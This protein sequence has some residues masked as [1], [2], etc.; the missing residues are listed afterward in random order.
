MYVV[1]R[2]FMTQRTIE[3]QC[4]TCSTTVYW[5]E[6]FPHRPFCSKRCQLIDFGEWANENHRIAGTP[7]DEEPVELET[8]DPDC[9]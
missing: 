1:S 9:Q 4:P 7:L 6:E 3:L 5:T 2:I 8:D